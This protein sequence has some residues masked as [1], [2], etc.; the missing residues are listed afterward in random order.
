MSFNI[1]TTKADPVKM[2]WFESNTFSLL[3]T[4]SPVGLEWS[5]LQK[6]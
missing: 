3:Y 4:I 5:N 1:D 2:F 6:A